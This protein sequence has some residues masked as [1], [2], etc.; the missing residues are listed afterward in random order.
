MILLPPTSTRTYTLFPYTTLF[1]SLHRLRIDASGQALQR[2]QPAR[3]APGEVAAIQVHRLV[4]GEVVAAVVEHAQPVVRDF[5]IGAV[6]VDDVERTVGQAALGT[7]VVDAFGALRPSSEDR[8]VWTGW[9]LTCRS[10]C[11][12]FY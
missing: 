3:R 11:F 10:R 8:R 2:R 12:R 4:L 7:V 6:Q 9:F 1:R 5:R